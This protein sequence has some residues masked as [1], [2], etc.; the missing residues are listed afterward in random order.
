MINHTILSE[1][2][3]ELGQ[4]MAKA[5]S[6]ERQLESESEH[7]YGRL[8]NLHRALSETLLRIRHIKDQ[9]SDLETPDEPE[10][11]ITVMGGDELAELSK[12]SPEVGIGYDSNRGRW[13]FRKKI[14]GTTKVIAQAK[15][16]AE[17]VA[18]KRDWEQK[19]RTGQQ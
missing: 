12:T 9:I 17:I 19:Q 11:A 15:T 6:F 14:N 8:A 5:A 13:R 7:N 1:L 18:L 16:H 2:Y 10:I 3:T 4:V